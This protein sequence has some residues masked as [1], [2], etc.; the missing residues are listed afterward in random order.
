M[1]KT[2]AAALFALLAATTAFAQ[3]ATKNVVPGCHAQADGCAMICLTQE[4]HKRIVEYRE[5]KGQ[6]P[7]WRPSICEGTHYGSGGCEYAEWSLPND[8]CST[9]CA[10]KRVGAYGG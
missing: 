6:Q 10:P 4:Q 3:G 1:L 5:K 8:P 2:M 9:A 7:I